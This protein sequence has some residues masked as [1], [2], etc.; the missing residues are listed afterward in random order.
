[1]TINRD[2][3]TPENAWVRVALSVPLAVLGLMTL[4][5]LVGGNPEWWEFTLPVLML[6]LSMELLVF[7]IR[8]V[9]YH[10]HHGWPVGN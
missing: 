6:V 5:T 7:G 2:A 4:A 3:T 8:D 9:G 1:M 10:A